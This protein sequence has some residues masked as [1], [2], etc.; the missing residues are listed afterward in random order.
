MTDISNVITDVEK[1]VKNIMSS[2]NVSDAVHALVGV[3]TNLTGN[4]ANLATNTAG[5]VLSG[6]ADVVGAA[7]SSVA[8]ALSSIESLGEDAVSKFA[9]LL[10]SNNGSDASN[11]NPNGN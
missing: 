4:I 5:H 1:D 11:T 7:G 10:R 6:T 3:I 9:N 2:S 8:D